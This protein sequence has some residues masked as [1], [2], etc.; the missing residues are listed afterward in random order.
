LLPTRQFPSS[1]AFDF[2]VRE[3][4]ESH[5]C[6]NSGMILMNP[7][8][9][10]EEPEII[11]KGKSSGPQDLHLLLAEEYEPRLRWLSTRNS[12]SNLRDKEQK[13]QGQRRYAYQ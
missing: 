1:A 2:A 7:R 5:D 10:A 3:P 13:E 9:G 8:I 4:L 11:R 12:F 6:H